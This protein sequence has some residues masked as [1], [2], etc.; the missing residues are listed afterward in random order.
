MHPIN[1]LIMFS[2]TMAALVTVWM[3][4]DFYRT[5]AMR[6]ALVHSLAHDLEFIRESPYIWECDWRSQCDD[7]RFKKLRGIIR[8][9]IEQLG[10]ARPAAVLAPLDQAD[11]RH[12]YRYV[13]SLVRAV[14][15]RHQLQPQ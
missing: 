13:R 2:L 5:L 7:Q 8:R 10:F 11:L 4:Y 15:K 1:M 6:S 3:C 12:R 14:E 9:H